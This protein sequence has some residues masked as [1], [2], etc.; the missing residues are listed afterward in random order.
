MHQEKTPLLKRPKLFLTLAV[1]C[2]LP[3]L[4]ISLISFRN[5]LK[6]TERLLRNEAADELSDVSRHY[7]WLIDE[8]ANELRTLTRGPLPNYIRSVNTPEAVALVDSN[9]QGPSSG[10]AAEA[11]VMLRKAI[12]DLPHPRLYFAQLGCFDSNRKLMFLAQP[13]D[14]NE[15]PIIR[16]KDFLPGVL[17]SDQRVWATK[18]DSAL[19]SIA[20]HPTFGDVLRCSM[21]IFLSS[22]QYSASARG[23]LV[24][25]IRLDRLLETAAQGP[26]VPGGPPRAVIVLNDARQIVYHPNEA[27]RHQPVD[28]ALPGFAPLALAMTANLDGGTGE[29][30]SSE[31]ETWIAAYLPLFPGLFLAVARNYSVASQTARATAGWASCCRSCLASEPRPC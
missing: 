11:A 24:A 17:E 9:Q 12:T 3:L 19:C 14:L 4:V 22:E 1:L 28:T 5:G 20:L 6:N 10:P 16:T 21:P 2:T 8:R 15:S 26:D 23:A 27:I 7:Q 13:V 25:D 18:G 29:Y 30:R 31:G